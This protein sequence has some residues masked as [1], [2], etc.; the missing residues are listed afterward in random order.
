[1][2]R[3]VGRRFG[4]ERERLGAGVA[5]LSQDVARPPGR[6]AASSIGRRERRPGAARKSATVFAGTRGSGRPGSGW[7][8]TGRAR[9][10][11]GRARRGTDA[12]PAARFRRPARARR[13]R[14]RGCAGA[15]RARARWRSVGERSRATG[16]SS[17][18]ERPRLAL[19]L[20]EALERR[21]RLALEGRQ[22]LE[23]LGQRLVLRRRARR[24]CCRSRRSRR[25]APRRARSS[26]SKTTP[27]SRTRP[28][29]ATFWRS[30][31]STISEASVRNGPRLPSASLRS[32]AAA[33]DR[34]RRVR[35]PALERGARLLVEGVED[36]VDLGRLARLAD[37]ERAALLD[38]L[39]RVGLGVGDVGRRAERDRCRLLAGL[40]A[41]GEL[42]VGLAEQRLL[43]Q[44]RPRVVGDRRELGL[45]L[46]H[47]LGR[48]LAV[49]AGSRAAPGSISLTLPTETPPIR[50]SD[51]TASCGRP[52]GSRR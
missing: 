41:G 42:D 6:R 49:D 11:P 26:A 35:L 19:E 9:R 38:R 36:L 32:S 12:A 31:M 51:S 2:P 5:E 28:F 3:L 37:A 30:R 44:D 45:D 27:V 1:M 43:A 50:T 20:V 52:R 24:R 23:G 15:A 48:V 25:R 29:S 13:G 18:D 46:D 4:A 16:I 40:G 8:G 7:R 17:L 33:L 14:R 39:D 10:A 34:D 22:D 47:G 21:P